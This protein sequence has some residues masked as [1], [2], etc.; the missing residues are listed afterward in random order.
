MPGQTVTLEPTPI[1]APRDADFALVRAASG[2]DVGAFE[3]LYRQHQRRIYAVLW[4]L[5][6][7]H[8]AR[9]EDLTQDVFLRAWRALPSFRFESAFSTWLHRLAVN[10]GLME[11]RSRSG[12]EDLETGD[13]ALHWHATGDSA[14]HRTALARDLEQAIARLPPRARA[15]LVLFDI[16]GWSH[17]EIAIE[18]DMAIGSSKAQLHR[19]RQLLRTCLGT[20][21]AP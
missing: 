20:G 5:C 19:A 7:G 6:G 17:E 10:T 2:G 8:R 21:D 4:R 18:L 12:A 3:A 15:V 1:A 13:D 11:L 16:E 9:A 14:G